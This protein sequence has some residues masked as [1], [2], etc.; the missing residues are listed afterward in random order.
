MSLPQRAFAERVDDATKGDRRGPTILDV[1][2]IDGRASASS[3]A[4]LVAAP[5]QQTMRIARSGAAAT[6]GESLC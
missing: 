2:D 4:E 3:R 5:P 1:L 6:T